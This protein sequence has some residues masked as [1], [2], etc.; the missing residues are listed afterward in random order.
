M[1]CNKF[2]FHVHTYMYIHVCTVHAYIRTYGMVT[3]GVCDDTL[4]LNMCLLNWV[5]DNYQRLK[6]GGIESLRSVA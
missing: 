6:G 5:L 1:L 4:Y 3:P 2:M